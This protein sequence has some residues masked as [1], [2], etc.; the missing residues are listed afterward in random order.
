MSFDSTLSSLGYDP[1]FS[2]ALSTISATLDRPGLVP[3]RVVSNLGAQVVLAG[4]CAS[5]A[6]LSGLLRHELAPVERPTVG[7]WVAIADGADARDRAVIHGVLPR[8]TAL[9]RRAAGKRGEPQAIAANV[10]TFAVVTSA[11]RDANARRLERYLAAIDDSGA[12]AVVVLNKADLC[13]PGELDEL[14]AELASS[15]RAVPIV[16]TSAATGDG[17]ESL[18][19]WVGPGKTLALVG[20]SGVGKSSLVNR[21]LG[22]EHQPVLAVDDNDR[23]R[24]ATTRRELLPLPN[25]AVLIDTPGMRSFGLVEDDGGLARGFTDVTEVAA[26]C[27]FRDC[28]HGGEPG[29]AVAAAVDDGSLDPDRVA[30]FH[31]LD[32]EAAAAERRRDPVAAGRARQHRKVINAALRARAKIDPKLRR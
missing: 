12:A 23:G 9:V 7:D 15:A 25:G 17:V 10:D 26:T 18:L 21:L 14:R 4:A 20:M 2:D 30:A 27:R 1:G 11:N 3:A 5:H 31:K 13:A 22:A 19:A 29:C 32:R 28:R 8:R 24:H 6:E 16:T